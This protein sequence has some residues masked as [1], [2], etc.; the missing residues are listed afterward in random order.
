MSIILLFVTLRH[1]RQTFMTPLVHAKHLFH[2]YLDFFKNCSVPSSTPTSCKN[3]SFKRLLSGYMPMSAKLLMHS[4][5]S[6]NARKYL[7]GKR[8][9]NLYHHSTKN[10]WVNK[11]GCQQILSRLNVVSC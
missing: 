7:P 11:T 4:D 6:S 2:L 3:L 8:K 1:L 10:P 5:K 9:H